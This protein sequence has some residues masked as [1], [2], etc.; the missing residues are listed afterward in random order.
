[1]IRQNFQNKMNF[2]KNDTDEAT[3]ISREY[4]EFDEFTER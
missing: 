3:D 4:E 1:M 2:R